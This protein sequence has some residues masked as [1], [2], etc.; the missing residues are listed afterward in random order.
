LPSEEIRENLTNGNTSDLVEDVIHA[1]GIKE[2]IQ[3][4]NE[5]ERTEVSED[6]LEDLEQ[7][8]ETQRLQRA[9]RMLHTAPLGIT[10]I[11]GYIIAKVIEVQNLRMLIRA[12]E[13]DIQ[14]LETI[15]KNLVLA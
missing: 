1:D 13:T 7:A 10:S 3:V 6:Q 12:K 8:L 15:R 14:N 4:V 5:S 9:L 11:L 2:A